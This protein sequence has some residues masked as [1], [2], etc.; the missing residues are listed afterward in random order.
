MSQAD[1]TQFDYIV[2]GGGIA[3][4]SIGYELSQSEK[5]LLLEREDAFGYHTTGRSA[6]TYIELLQDQSIVALSRA[7]KPFLSCPPDGFSE[8]PLLTDCGCIISANYSELPQLESLFKQASQLGIETQWLNSKQITEKIPMIR[9]DKEAVY[10]GLLEPQAKR[11]DVDG[12]LQGY[13]KGLRARGGRTLHNVQIKQISRAKQRWQVQTMEQTFECSVLVNAAGA[14]GDFL[15]A[16]AGVSAIGLEPKKRTMVTFDGPADTEISTWP[17][18][19]NI[20][21]SFY[22]LP[23]SGQLMGS[24]ADQS[25][26]PPCDARP[27][28]LDIATAIYNIEQ[29]THLKISK[30]NH[31]WAGLRTFSPDRLPVIGFEPLTKDFFWFVGQGGF[32]IQTAPALA[33]LGAALLLDKN[34]KATANDLNVDLALLLPNRFR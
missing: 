14:W 2:I 20:S 18:M 13:L 3:G 24:P 25:P 1:P 6:A 15:A 26:S 8:S 17:M 34:P 16:K 32:G 10:A 12:L 29:H 22:F 21:S 27:D 23:E 28:E 9:A 31:S 33:Q 4:A 30:V 7:S 11:V 5:V 19:G